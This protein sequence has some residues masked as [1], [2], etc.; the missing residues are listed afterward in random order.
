MSG[1]LDESVNTGNNVKKSASHSACARR[2]HHTRTLCQ[3]SG[4]QRHNNTQR[5]DKSP[6]F[7][8]VTNHNDKTSNNI[9]KKHHITPQHNTTYHITSHHIT[10]Q[11][12]TST[13]HPHH[14]HITSHH[15]TS[16][17]MTPHHILRNQQHQ[18]QQQ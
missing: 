16:H 6:H 4:I 17:H 12:I 5:G 10:T 18:H 8:T 15:I 7:I 9:R 2:H 3:G 11:H 13:S 1:K 14:I